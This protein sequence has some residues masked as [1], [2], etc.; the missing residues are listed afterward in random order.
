LLEQE[1]ECQR[2]EWHKVSLVVLQNRDRQGA[3]ANRKRA[4]N[5]LFSTGAAIQSVCRLLT[6]AVP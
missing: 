6:R 1:E 5:A 4:R 2:V 3:A